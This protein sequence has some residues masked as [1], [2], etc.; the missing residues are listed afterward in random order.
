MRELEPGDYV[1][2][3]VGEDTSFGHVHAVGDDIVYVKDGD[4]VMGVLAERVH[5]VFR[6]TKAGSGS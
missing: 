2:F 5:F 1:Q 6:P 4:E 3:S